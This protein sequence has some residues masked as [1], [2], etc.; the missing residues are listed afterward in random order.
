[1][2][3]GVVIACMGSRNPQ[4][5]RSG[6]GVN[7]TGVRITILGLENDVNQFFI[8]MP[9]ALLMQDQLLGI[10]FLVSKCL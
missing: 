3:G 6:S 4:T 7:K 9:K 8:T 1:M 10:Y 5:H 2:M